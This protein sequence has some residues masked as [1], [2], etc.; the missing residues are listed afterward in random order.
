MAELLSLSSIVHYTIFTKN[1][2]YGSIVDFYLHDKSWIVEF[3]VV[4][5]GNIFSSKK[6][7][8]PPGLIITID[9][10]SKKL[11]AIADDQELK[12]LREASEVYKFSQ[13]R[14]AGLTPKEWSYYWHMRNA[15][16]QRS[17]SE[18]LDHEESILKEEFSRNHLIN[19]SELSTY[20]ILNSS[21]KG[22]LKDI[23]VDKNSWQAI[24]GVLE[25][26]LL[27]N[28]KQKRIEI[29]CIS[30]IKWNKRSIKMQELINV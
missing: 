1:K 30:D 27:W 6:I 3:I 25:N 10:N 23:L 5:T 7:L 28:K 12:R 16:D 29:A 2:K 9:T 15:P 11:I 17:V 22:H 26:G 18:M 13:M 20:A 8:F 24:S 19:Y 21:I 4:K 14:Y